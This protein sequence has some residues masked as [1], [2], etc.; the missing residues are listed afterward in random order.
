MRPLG[1]SAGTRARRPGALALLAALA[2]AGACA[3]PHASAPAPRPRAAVQLSDADVHALAALLRLEDRRELDT[4][5]LARFSRSATPEVRRRAY[6]AAGR[7]GGPGA[8]HIVRPGLRDSVPRVR[9]AAAF[10]LG[11]LRDT[12]SVD[13]LARVALVGHGTDAEEAVFALGRM[14]TTAAHAALQA[15]LGTA[16]GLSGIERSRVGSIVVENNYNGPGLSFTGTPSPAVIGRTL[17]AVWRFKRQPRDAE[18]VRGFAASPDTA[19]R[20]RAAYALMRLADR[21]TVPVLERLLADPYPEVRA[22]AARGLRAPVADSANARAEAQ[23]RLV[24]ALQDSAPH[25][26]INAAGALASYRDPALVPPLSDLLRDADAN[27]ALAAAQ[28]LGSLR[29]PAAAAP[30]RAL[31]QDTTARLA[32]RA[33]ALTALG[34]LDP[35]AGLEDAAAWAA[36]AS[37]RQRFYAASALGAPGLRLALPA[38]AALAHDPDSRVVAAALGAQGTVLGDSIAPPRPLLIEQLG[39]PDP[40]VRAAAIAVLA[41]KP[42]A[43]DLELFLDSY[44]RAARD[45]LDDAALAAVDALAAL[46]KARGPAARDFFARFSRSGDYVVRRAV[47]ERLGGAWGP[48][49]P[50]GTGRDSAF[51]LDVVRRLVVPALAGG[52][53]PRV[54]ITTDVGVPARPGGLVLELDAADSPLTVDNFLRL[55][56]AH[57]YDKAMW[58]RVVPNFVVQD[59]DPRGDGNGGPG[60]AIR[61]E[62]NDS[63]YLRGALGMALSG[64]DT[65]GSQ[66]FLTLSS[67]PHLDAGYTLFGHLVDGDEVLDRIVQDDVIRTVDVMP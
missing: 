30:L 54:R 64:P 43:A 47:A 62:L 56:A 34:R 53:G 27:V 22:L 29:Q 7:I 1:R 9:A 51:Y 39:A 10:A 18:I 19:L 41:A 4:A 50:V 23:S 6:L 45:S 63:P 36:A 66:F 17:L 57:Y 33:A 48:V 16:G 65:G 31:V 60:W 38:L 44:A 2:L 46:Q 28:A 55:A 12:A 15:V 58:H 20:W 3:R 13:S 49:T 25:V 21:A 42:D 8:A 52:P 5:A 59:G 61:D 67:Q 35:R 26:R 32:L 37:W 14:S 11:L 24:A 40:I